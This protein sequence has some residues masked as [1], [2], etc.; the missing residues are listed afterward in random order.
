MASI[1]ESGHLLF[2]YI[3]ILYLPFKCWLQGWHE[4]DSYGLIMESVLKTYAAGVERL[5]GLQWFRNRAVPQSCLS[6][7]I[8]D[9]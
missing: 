7:T 4:K 9:T 8:C 1:G 6:I 3:T 5:N 2:E